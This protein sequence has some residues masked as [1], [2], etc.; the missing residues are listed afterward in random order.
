V[1]TPS[2]FG[3]NFTTNTQI[4]YAPPFAFQFN[5]TTPNLSDYNFTWYFG[6]GSSLQ[7]NN[8]S[9][10]HQYAQNGLYN[11]SLTATNTT[12]GCTETKYENGYIYCAGGTSCTQTATIAQSNPVN[13]CVGVPV[14]LSCNTVAGATYQWNYNGSTI[15]GYDTTVYYA[16]ASGNYSVTIILN[17]CP[18]TS[19]VITVNLNNPPSVPVI[20]STGSLTYCG[21]GKDTLTVPAGASSYLWSNGATTN[22]TIVSTSGNY[23]VQVSNAQGC[24]SQSQPYLVGASPLSSPDICIV[25]VD[26]ATGHNIVTWKK[27]VS[28]D[29]NHYN[30]YGQGNQANVFDLLGSVPYDSASV[31][32]DTASN[33]AQQAYLYELS[34]VDTCGAESAL[35]SYQETIHLSINQGMGSTYNLL[36]NFYEGFTFPSYNIYRGTSPLNMILLKTLASTLNSYTDLNP[37]SGYVYYQIGV[38]NPNPCSASTKIRGSVNYTSSRSN[39]ASNN[40][41]IVITGINNHND[42][43][44]NISIYP[45]PANDQITIDNYSFAKNQ[46]I[47]VYNIQGQLL[48]R[49]PMLQAKTSIDVSDFAKGL[50]FIMVNT[51]NGLTVKRFVKE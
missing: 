33:P 1:V 22:S 7:S 49:I 26:S 46:T 2:N 10:F 36:W 45:N 40:N 27:P 4:L 31:F 19:S 37:P 8:A 21:G 35:S 16:S 41:N 24:T 14:K 32:I 44:A 43:L 9:V 30:V 29:I 13:G 38:V 11:I 12:T 48:L 18:V 6:D 39:I 42:N 34:I 15:S 20:T 47:S 25:S 3:V 17:S 5:N 50:Y 23:T 28:T 51:E